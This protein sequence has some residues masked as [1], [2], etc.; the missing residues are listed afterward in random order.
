MTESD[1]IAM[2]QFILDYEK[3]YHG[4]LFEWKRDRADNSEGFITKYKNLR[5]CLTFIHRESHPSENINY[6]KHMRY[7][8]H[9]IVPVLYQHVC[10]FD[11]TR[12]FNGV[13]KIAYLFIDRISIPFAG[14]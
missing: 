14:R 8:G 1:G 6:I 5:Y 7:R 4:K 3:R 13:Y 9:M 11:N 12:L 2:N 10:Y